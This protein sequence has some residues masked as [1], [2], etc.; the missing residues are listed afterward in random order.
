MKDRSHFLHRET[1][2]E[3][4]RK[5]PLVQQKRSSSSSLN[6]GLTW[7]DTLGKFSDLASNALSAANVFMPRA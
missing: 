6:P 7:E 3:S 1:T 5:V 4:Q 2:P